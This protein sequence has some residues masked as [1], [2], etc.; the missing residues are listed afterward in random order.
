LALSTH[1]FPNSQTVP[2]KHCVLPLQVLLN[3]L[4]QL[5]PVFRIRNVYPGSRI[6]GQKEKAPY[7][8]FGSANGNKELG[9]FKPKR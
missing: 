5:I 4:I 9:I 8:G 1:T 7:P 2:E 3:Q 6:Q